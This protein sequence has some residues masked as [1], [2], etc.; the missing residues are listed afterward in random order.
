MRPHKL[1]FSGIGSYPGEVVVDFDELSAKGLYLIVGPTGAGK[2]TLLDAIT[3][4]LYGKVAQSRE[5]AIVSNHAHRKSPSIE[6][7]FS[8]GGRRYRVRRE[9]APPGKNVN[10]NKQVMRE[11]GPTGDE[12]RTV[13]G[14]RQVNEWAK[15]IVGLSAE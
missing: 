7:E 12:I 5:N 4:A 15:E 6:F 3:F 9:P 10:T 14:V 2:T 8:Q 11:I 1:A 13:T